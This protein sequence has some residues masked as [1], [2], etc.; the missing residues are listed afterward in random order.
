MSTTFNIRMFS[1]S[2]QNTPIIVRDRLSFSADD[3]ATFVPNIRKALGAEVAILSTCNR[4]EFYFYGD[5]EIVEWGGL[6]AYIANA[7]SFGSKDELMPQDALGD[8]AARHLFRV[9]SSM[10][11]LALGEDQILVQVKDV[12]QQILGH[13]TKS[14]VL[15]KLYQFAIRT[16]KRVRTETLLCEG[17]VSISS[18]SVSLAKRIFGRLDKLEIALVGAGETAAST[19]EH[20][21]ANK[22]NHFVIVNRGEQRGNALADRFSGE[23]RKLGLLLEVCLSADVMVFATDA[24]AYLLKASDLKRVMKK[25][26]YRPLFLIDISNPRNIDPEISK[27]SGVYLYN[28][29][30]LQD[31]IKDNLAARQSEIPKAEAIIE[32][33]VSE[34]EAWLRT[35]KVR[36]TIANLVQ[37]FEDLRVQ[38]MRSVENKFNERELEILDI[39]SKRLTKKLLHHP[40]TYLRKSVEDNDLRTENVEVVRELFALNKKESDEK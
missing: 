15:D 39:F 19:A 36:P 37:F 12:H 23:Y 26:G 16:G 31:V 13:Q 11:S 9:A 34:W 7:K 20:F 27:I 6:K 38:E 5:P 22:V 24:Q 32:E 14:P 4:T 40:I 18:A 10:E 1:F 35:V 21:H 2:H 8:A 33:M 28:I 29:D 3:V 30:D 25:R 17:A